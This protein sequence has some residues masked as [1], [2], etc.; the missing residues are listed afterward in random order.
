MVKKQ[1]GWTLMELIVAAAIVGT[2]ALFAPK[3]IT[4]TVQFFIL[5]K[6]RLELQREARGIMYFVTRELRQAQ[7]ATIVVDQI[8]NQPYYSRIQFT[9]IQGTAVTIAQTGSTLVVTYGT[10]V[11]TMTRNLAY[12]SFNFPKSD[13][14]TIISVSITLQEKIYNGAYKALHMA[15][16]RVRV[17]N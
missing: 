5:G 11:T 3:I 13:D 6:A 10:T 12:L 2:I 4:G 7:S 1:G 14:M 9:K 16:E 17:M 15:S 8:N